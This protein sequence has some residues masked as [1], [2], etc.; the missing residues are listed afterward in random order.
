MGLDFSKEE[1]GWSQGFLKIAGVD[2]AGRGPL[3]GPVVAAAVV[4]PSGSRLEGLDDS[5]KISPKKREILFCE[6]LKLA[7]VGIGIVSEKVIDK[8]NILQAARQAMKEAVEALKS[9]PDCLLIDGNVRINLPHKQQ[10]IVHGDALVASIAAASI[11]AKVTRDRLM[12]EYH[13]QYPEYGFDGHKGY[14]APIHIE[15]I[16]K[17]GLS[18]IHRRSFKVRSLEGI[19][20]E[21][22][23]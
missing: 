22:R 17:L 14:P 11:V 13:A 9:D 5:K 12:V 21:E 19:L 3:A 23:P 1:K 15:A 6:I 20:F 10:T 7:D 8:I 16:K 18:P 4:F 2:E